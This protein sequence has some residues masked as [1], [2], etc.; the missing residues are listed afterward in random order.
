MADEE[1]NYKRYKIVPCLQFYGSS[2]F[3]S[4]SFPGLKNI[5]ISEVKQ[6]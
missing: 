5:H 1:F 3:R 2:L 6:T 4:P